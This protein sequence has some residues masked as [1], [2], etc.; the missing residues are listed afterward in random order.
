MFENN[1]LESS[2]SRESPLQA[3]DRGY[4]VLAGILGFVAG[5]GLLPLI[6]APASVGAHVARAAILGAVVM[7]WGFMLIYVYREARHLSFKAWVWCGLVAISN[8]A[9]FVLFLIYSA[10]RTGKWQRATIPIAYAMEICL[11]GALVL[12]PLLHTAS[13]GKAELGREVWRVPLAP[14][15]PP[16]PSPAPNTARRSPRPANDVF[17]LIVPDAIPERIEMVRDDSFD[18]PGPELAP[19]IPGG[20]DGGTRGGIPFSIATTMVPP[21]PP[22]PPVG[23]KATK[24]R[25][26][27]VSHIDP[28]KLIFQP[29][30]EYPPVARMA[31]I[32][33]TVRLE[34]VIG[35]DG[36]VE[37]LKVVSGHPL[38]LKAAV[39]AISRWRYQ[40]TLL[41]GEPVEVLTEIDVIFQLAGQ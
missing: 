28:A 16:A 25:Q 12:V 32:E 2:P 9:G 30:P 38:F 17:V 31:R 10:A 27:R 15:P 7:C 23:T 1:L 18:V 40:P 19:G 8:L 11:V 37:N 3:G 24:P 4:A 22:P 13:L 35:T 6:I 33:G 14:P 39:D 36:R 29:K 26:V 20:M 21:L 41:N 5:L 34:A